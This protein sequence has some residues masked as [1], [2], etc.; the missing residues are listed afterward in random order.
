MKRVVAG[1]VLICSIMWG[2]TLALANP[3]MLPAHPG[4]TP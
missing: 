4:V 1:M 2:G 3:A